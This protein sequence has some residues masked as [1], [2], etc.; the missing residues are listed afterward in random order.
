MPFKNVIRNLFSFFFHKLT[1]TSQKTL[2]ENEKL[3]KENISLQIKVSESQQLKKENEDLKEALNFKSNKEF[4]L[5]GVSVLSFSPSSWR[6][7]LLINAGTD[8]GLEKD[9][10]AVDKSG[11]LIGKI[12]EV[13]KTFSHLLLVND[14]NFNLSVF[15]GE[16]SSGLL[17][18]NLTGAKVLYI[19]ENESIKKGDRIWVRAGS[20]TS[21]IEVGKVK[22][23]RKG[24]DQLF[25]D[26]TVQL[27][28]G[29]A[30]FDKV[31]I[32]K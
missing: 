29:D 28:P 17:K 25:C 11:K 6:R 32:L 19:E 2:Q 30:F 4:D 7:Y 14:P 10:L 27:P 23:I 16:F 15:V 8:S 9:L 26:I 20:S 18:G 21:V 5:I 1:I 3:R 22:S 12:T 13:K 31:F 24:T